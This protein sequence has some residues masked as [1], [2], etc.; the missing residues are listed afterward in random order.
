MAEQPGNLTIRQDR[1]VTALLDPRTESIAEA[2]RKAGY[3]HRETASAILR[4]PT[5]QR[6]IERRK[7]KAAD[8]AKDLKALSASKLAERVASDDAS[9]ALVLGTYKTANDVLASGVEEDATE[10]ASASDYAQAKRKLM[11]A[12]RVGR[13]LERRKMRCSPQSNVPPI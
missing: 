5:V 10:A 3:A 1:L 6:E 7:A 8:K 12:V 4:S 13:Y 9:D 11:Q 2:G